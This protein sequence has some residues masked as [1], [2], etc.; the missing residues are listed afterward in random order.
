MPLKGVFNIS[1]SYAQKKKL[2]PVMSENQDMSCVRSC[3]VNIL[4]SATPGRALLLFSPRCCISEAGFFQCM[5]IHIYL[6][7]Y[8]PKSHLRLCP[9]QSPAIAR[10]RGMFIF[11]NSETHSPII[12]VFIFSCPQSMQR[13]Q[14]FHEALAQL[15][16]GRLSS[17]PSLLS[18]YMALQTATRGQRLK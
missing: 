5:Y 15:S 16:T 10:L 4:C 14:F 1:F 17:S 6:G 9:D 2:K 8:A 7:M 13:S 3:S 11:S 12:F 18:T